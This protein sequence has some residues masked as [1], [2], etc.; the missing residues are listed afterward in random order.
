MYSLD[1]TLHNCITRH[2]EGAYDS[3]AGRRSSEAS[4]ACLQKRA[5]TRTTDDS[6]AEKKA[7]EEDI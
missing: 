4:N 5:L 6:H 3:S 7:F 2:I 1:I